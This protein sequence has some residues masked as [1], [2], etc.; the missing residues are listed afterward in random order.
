MAKQRIVVSVSVNPELRER[1]NKAGDDVNWSAVACAA[2]EEKL[3]EIE[4]LKGIR[5]NAETIE[6]MRQSKKRD[7]DDV[8]ASGWKCAQRW[9]H[10]TK[11]KADSPRAEYRELINLSER[12]EEEDSKDWM[13]S[14]F[15]VWKVISQSQ[16]S[17]PEY[18]RFWFGVCGVDAPPELFVR[19]FVESAIAEFREIARVLDGNKQEEMHEACRKA[20]ENAN[21]ASRIDKARSGQSRK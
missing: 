19:G 18:G 6:Y 3:A 17:Q 16:T 13:N 1:M 21:N 10:G 9:I 20:A 5:V 15:E 7:F 4:R 11:G 8:Y 2:F 14:Y 12:C